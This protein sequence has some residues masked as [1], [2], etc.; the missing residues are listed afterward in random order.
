MKEAK[1][2]QKSDLLPYYHQLL[3]RGWK[4]VFIGG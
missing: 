3:E 2:V 4:D 1:S